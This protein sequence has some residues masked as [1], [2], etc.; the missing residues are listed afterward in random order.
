M[1]SSARHDKNQEQ[2]RRFKGIPAAPGIIIGEATV[3]LAYE[4]YL[5]N[6]TIPPEAVG[7]ELERLAAAMH[8]SAEE[9]RHIIE[10]AQHEE[11]SVLPILETYLLML[12]DALLADAIRQRIMAGFSAESAVYQEFDAQKQFFANAKDM[13]LRER[14]ADLDNVRERLLAG[15]RNCIVSH[16]TAAEKVLIATSVT[17]TDLMLYR[18]SGILGFATEVGG[19]ASHTSILARSFAMPAVIGVRGIAHVVKNGETIIL[20]GYAGVLVVNPKTETLLKYR[21]RQAEEEENRRKLGKLAKVLAETSD[22]RKIHLH[23]NIDSLEDVDAAMMFGAEGIG[24]VRTEYLIARQHRFPTEDEQYEWYKEIAERAYPHPITIRAFDVGGDKFAEAVPKEDNPALGLRGVRFLLYKKDIFR[25]QVRAVLRASVHRNI[26][27]M[28]PMIA[29]LGEFQAALDFIDSCRTSLAKAEIPFDP[30]TPIGIMIET[31]AAAVMADEFAKHA[32]FFSIGTNDL[33][34][35]TLAADR[36]NEHI[37]AIFDP[38]D[39]AVLRLM[40]LAVLAAKKWGIPIGIC[41]EIAGHP[42]ATELLVGLGVDELSVTP[43]SLLVLKKRILRSNAATAEDVAARALG[44]S[45]AS[46]VRSL[47][48]SHRSRARVEA[49]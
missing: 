42:N 31:P 49:E 19:I 12:T 25:S 47:L 20:D 48:A 13:L 14:A 45:D 40:R 5:Q 26:R 32:D 33:T 39:P 9:Y 34:Q 15:L 17:P 16:A 36:T 4:N 3:L 23:A 37:T 18:K 44:C 41:G 46:K 11:H 2:E 30:A 8:S 10:I 6:E 27:L 29:T 43:N 24:L 38:F 1:A 7:A 35:Y 21:K 22:G 28:L